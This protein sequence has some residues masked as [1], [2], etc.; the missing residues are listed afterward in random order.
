M[1]DVYSELEQSLPLVF[2]RRE[3][4]RLLGGLISC[5]RLANLDSE[6]SGPPKIRLGKKVGY[7]RGPFIAW[8][9]ARGGKHAE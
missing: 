2:T 3:V 7:P 6:G 5:G 8:M 4:S 1:I 9:R